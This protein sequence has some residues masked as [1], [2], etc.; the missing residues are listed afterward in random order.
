[1]GDEPV[2]FNKFHLPGGWAHQL[3][4]ESAV[5][6]ERAGRGH[7]PASARRVAESAG[8]VAGYA[9]GHDVSARLKRKAWQTVAVGQ[10]VR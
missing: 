2:I 9:C 6:F 4:P 7:R 1:V 10:V 8:V 5:D 3:P